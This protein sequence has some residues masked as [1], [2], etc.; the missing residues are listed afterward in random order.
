MKKLLVIAFSVSLGL[1]ATF[2]G[3]VAAAAESLSSKAQVGYVK[4]KSKKVYYRTKHGSKVVYR[5]SK[6]ETKKGFH[7]SK[8]VTKHTYSKTKDKV[9]N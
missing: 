1:T 8:R 4:R 9:T 5:K 3:S 2:L 7:K 6:R